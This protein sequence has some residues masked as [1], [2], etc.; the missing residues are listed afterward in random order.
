MDDDD[1]FSGD[2]TLHDESLT[3]EEEERLAKDKVMLQTSH[4]IL[5]LNGTYRCPFCIGR[6]K[7]D[8]LYNQ[9]M[10]HALSIGRGGTGLKHRRHKLLHDR[11][12]HNELMPTTVP[13]QSTA[14]SQTVSLTKQVCEMRH[15]RSN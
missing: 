13:H 12:Q 1:E 15:G 14:L 2:N 7:Q 5:N 4:S 8:Y 9:I 6:M 11:L 10:T 3:D